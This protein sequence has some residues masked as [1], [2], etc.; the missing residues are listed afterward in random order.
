MSFDLFALVEKFVLEE[1]DSDASEYLS[2]LGNALKTDPAKITATFAALFDRLPSAGNLTRT[3]KRLRQ[4][5][6]AMMGWFGTSC[7]SKVLA[8]V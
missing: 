2:E 1:N 8:T 6:A 5:H 4:L 7:T 3:D